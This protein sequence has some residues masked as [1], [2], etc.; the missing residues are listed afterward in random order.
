MN[1]LI[2]FVLHLPHSFHWN[3]TQIT[4]LSTHLPRIYIQ[5]YKNN[6]IVLTLKGICTIKQN[7][8]DAHKPYSL[9]PDCI[10][11]IPEL[12]YTEF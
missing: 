4:M 11:T 5:Y 6:V 2:I 3:I 9:V 10:A 12:V 1:N 7:I 8:S